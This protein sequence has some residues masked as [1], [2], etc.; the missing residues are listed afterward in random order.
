MHV[1]RRRPD[2]QAQNQYGAAELSRRLGRSPTL[3]RRRR[4]AAR[5]VGGSN[6]SA[7]TGVAAYD[8][9][10]RQRCYRAF[11]KQ[12]NVMIRSIM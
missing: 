11:A 9:E 10:Y 3:I 5:R 6:M 12:V 4:L 2:G 8:I 7:E 1:G